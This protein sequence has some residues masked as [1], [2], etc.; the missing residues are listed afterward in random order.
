MQ[1]SW[2]LLFLHRYLNKFVTFK[3]C[4][5]RKILPSPRLR[6]Y[7]NCS[8]DSS[9]TRNCD[10]LG[11]NFGNCISHTVAHE[12]CANSVPERCDFSS[13]VLSLVIS[14]FSSWFSRCRRKWIGAD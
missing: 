1:W 5:H 3:R 10:K 2:W 7:A 8:R 11:S 13:D 14:G 4:C 12:E 9:L 6:K